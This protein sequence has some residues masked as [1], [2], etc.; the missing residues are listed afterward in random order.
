MEVAMNTKL[1]GLKVAIL[2]TDGFEQSEMTEPKK[3]LQDAGAH[4]DIIA[5]S[6]GKVKSWKNKNW[7]DEFQVDKDLEQ[8]KEEDYDALML[9]GGLM[10]PDKLRMNEKAVNFVKNF[11]K[12]RKP[13]ASICHGPLLLINA[14][15]VRNKTLTSYPS[16]KIDLMNAGAKWVDQEVAKDELLITSR[17]PDDIPAFNEAM[18][19]LFSKNRLEAERK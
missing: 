11:V 5:P 10:S 2:I 15:A 17:R 3:A 6:K 7:G 1:K 13:I 12:N 14:N 16:I 18:I 4:T 9:P 19:E 8:A